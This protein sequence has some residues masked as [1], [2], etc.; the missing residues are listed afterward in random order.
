MKTLKHYYLVTII[1]SLITATSSA[2]DGQSDKNAKISIIGG[3][4]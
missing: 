2:Q 3:L 1:F 4:T